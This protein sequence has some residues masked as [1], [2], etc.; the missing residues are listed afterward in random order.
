M[1]A[2][3]LV[4]DVCVGGG[5]HAHRV[6]NQGMRKETRKKK[7]QECVDGSSMKQARARCLQS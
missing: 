5:C 2:D 4:G 3:V 6:E 7:C 1:E